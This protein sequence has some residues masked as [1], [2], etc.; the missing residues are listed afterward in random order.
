MLST[1]PIYTQ[2]EQNATSREEKE[3][4]KVQFSKQLHPSLAIGLVFCLEIWRIV[5]QKEEDEGACMKNSHV[6]VGPSP[7]NGS[8]PYESVGYQG[9]QKADG[10]HQ[11]KES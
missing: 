2:Q 10:S 1:T 4:N 9:T 6:N 7:P 11:V 8:F 3:P 5:H